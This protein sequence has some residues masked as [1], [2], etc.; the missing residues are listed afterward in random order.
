MSQ[1]AD[2]EPVDPDVEV[3]AQEVLRYL[4]QHPEAADT[5]E[6]IARWWILR[7]RIEAALAKTQKALDYLESLGAIVRTPQGVY[8]LAPKPRR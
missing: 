4:E 7:Q 6:H 5:T 8:R 1:N 3:L 2:M